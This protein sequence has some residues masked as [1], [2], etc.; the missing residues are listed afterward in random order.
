[1]D[2]VCIG[3]SNRLSRPSNFREAGIYSHTLRP[4][5]LEP[6]GG[7]PQVLTLSGGPRLITWGLKCPFSGECRLGSRHFWNPRAC[8]GYGSALGSHNEKGHV[9]YSHV[10]GALDKSQVVMAMKGY[11][12]H[13]PISRNEASLSAPV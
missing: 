10:R 4:T 8:V 3:S 5:I 7:V 1:M 12:T 13:P 2:Q 6:W 11:S 9:P